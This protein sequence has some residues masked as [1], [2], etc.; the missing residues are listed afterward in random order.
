MR[1]LKYCLN[2]QLAKREARFFWWL[3]KPPL[4]AV[5]R[6]FKWVVAATKPC[7]CVQ[8]RQQC[9]AKTN[10]ENARIQLIE[11]RASVTCIRHW[12][13]GVYWGW[14]VIGVGRWYAIGRRW[15]AIGMGWLA[16]G[17]RLLLSTTYLIKNV[18]LSDMYMRARFVFVGSIHWLLSIENATV[19]LPCAIHTN[20][21]GTATV[22]NHSQWEDVVRVKPLSKVESG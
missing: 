18:F 3:Q 14:H 17:S 19:S 11:V 9:M 20:C 8:T 12:D 16:I 6:S 2:V 7:H 4:P 1:W 22:T 10:P 15:S 13:I 5:F 21:S